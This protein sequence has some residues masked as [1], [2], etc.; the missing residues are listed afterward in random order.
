MALYIVRFLFNPHL[1]KFLTEYCDSF[2]E[3][4]HC[5]KNLL[6]NIHRINQIAIPELIEDEDE[7]SD[8][9]DLGDLYNINTN[10]NKN[11]DK[12]EKE[13]K[14][15]ANVNNQDEIKKPTLTVQEEMFF[16]DLFIH[17]C[18]RFEKELFAKD[19]NFFEHPENKFVQHMQIKKIFSTLKQEEKD[20]I[21]SYLIGLRI[22]SQSLDYLTPKFL[23]LFSK[24][25]EESFIEQFQ[26]MNVQ[27]SEQLLS[28]KYITIIMSKCGQVME[29]LSKKDVAQVL[30]YFKYFL[31]HDYSPVWDMFPEDYHE[32]LEFTID[33]I[34]NPESK[35]QLLGFVKPYLTPM[36]KKIESKVP[37]S[38]LKIDDLKKKDTILDLVNMFKTTCQ[39]N[40]VDLSVPP[41]ELYDKNK[42][43]VDSTVQE[44]VDVE[45]MDTIN[46]LG[47][48]ATKKEAFEKF[49]TQYNEHKRS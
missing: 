2:P 4:S 37:I 47:N 40:G 32:M 44:Y 12:N 14:Q 19:D 22:I 26:D 3:L 21:W 16:F 5:K 42:N 33:M 49:K 30:P 48:M 43:V 10:I 35:E 7:S 17:S 36:M 6:D 29:G 8:D 31:T 27:T 18:K 38:K 11:T 1:E 25:T 41:A 20:L 28:E 24:L 34:E 23:K 46:N 9:E 15:V 39:E 45:T 13:E